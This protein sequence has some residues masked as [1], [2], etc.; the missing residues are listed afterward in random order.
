MERKE[1]ANALSRRLAAT[2]I[3]DKQMDTIVAELSRVG[4]DPKDVDICTVGICVDYFVDRKD[5][6]GLL[7]RLGE[8]PLGGPI[9]LFP[10]GIINPDLFVVQVDHKLRL[11]ESALASNLR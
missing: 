1:L 3:D 6:V 8:N 9:R 7:E 2:S 11:A 4:F 10:K 5:L